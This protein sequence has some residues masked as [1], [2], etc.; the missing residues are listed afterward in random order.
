MSPEARATRR[1]SLALAECLHQLASLIESTADADYTWRHPSGVSGSVGAHVRHCLDHVHAIIEGVGSH[2]TY[3]HRRRATRAE[4]DRGFALGQLHHAV[5][6]LSR[7]CERIEQHLTLDVQVDRDG[8][9]VSVASSFGRELAF[10]LQHTIHHKALIALL[11]ADRGVAVPGTFAL[12]P[13]TPIAPSPG[14]ERRAE[15][16]AYACAR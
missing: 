7:P 13:S 12:A 15:A 14:G 5:R 9:H 6:A 10:V 11:L 8:T 1:A 16:A 4:A 3:D 2:M